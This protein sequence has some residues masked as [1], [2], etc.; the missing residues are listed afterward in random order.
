MY[1]LN[2]DRN[3]KILLAKSI[4]KYEIFE[5]FDCCGTIEYSDQLRPQTRRILEYQYCHTHFNLHGSVFWRV[6]AL[7]QYQL[8]LPEFYLACGAYL[9][10]NTNEFP[11]LQ[12]E[13]GKTVFDTI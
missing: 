8:E 1:T 3:F 5:G 10:Q 4:Y 12:S 2:Y 13:K 11:T 9:E 7:N 6:R